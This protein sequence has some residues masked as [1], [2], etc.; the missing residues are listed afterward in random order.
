MPGRL[1]DERRP[2]PEILRVGPG[3]VE[4]VAGPRGVTAE[5]INLPNAFGDRAEQVAV[6]DGSE[7]LGAPALHPL[8]IPVRDRHVDAGVVVG[9]RAK[10]HSLFAQA[11]PPGVVI[12]RADELEFR[13]IGAEAEEAHA[14]RLLFRSPHHRGRVVVTLHRPDPVVEAVLEVADPAMGV[15]HAPAG[16]DHRPFVGDIV[17]RGVLEKDS[18]GSI[19]HQH[20]A[21]GEDERGGNREFL[22]EDGELVGPPVAVGVFT[23]LD[24]VAPL[25][26]GLE[27]VRVVEGFTKPEAAPF[28]PVHGDWFASELALVD[29]QLDLEVFE[30]LVVL[31]RLSRGDWLLHLGVGLALHAPLLARQVVRNLVPHLDVVEGGDILAG[32]RGGQPGER[33]RVVV[34]RGGLGVATDR[35]QHSPLDQVLETGVAPGF[36][37]VSPGGVEDPPLA[38]GADPGVGLGSL[39][40]DPAFE[41]DAVFVVVLVVHVRLIDAFEAVE[42]LHDRMRGLVDAGAEQF[43]TVPLELPT[44]QFDIPGRVEEAV[45]GT[46]QGD[47]PAAPLDIVEQRLL[48]SGGD[49]A[50]VGVDHQSVEAGEGRGV[51]HL[52]VVGVLDFDP[53]FAQ[54][55]D[56][57][58]GTFG[59]AMMPTVAQEQHLDRR[60]GG[61]QRNRTRFQHAAHG[62]KHQPEHPPPTRT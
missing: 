17:P 44:H 1:A 25:P 57:L 10:D 21:T 61:V 62:E 46:V 32:R 37:V 3:G 4:G 9:G 23:D 18:L 34:D 27:F 8:V 53:A 5:L 38:L 48:L 52:D 11:Q 20:P 42:A 31:L 50:D 26:A 14:E 58:R 24:L 6:G 54:D 19:L 39:A 47:E 13:A 45:G 36:F 33:A 41:H 29:E 30:R 56:Q 43:E 59:R 2:V 7:R 60:F 22:G 12:G 55:G 35:P 40:I 28:I 49:L 15:P 16:K 51:E